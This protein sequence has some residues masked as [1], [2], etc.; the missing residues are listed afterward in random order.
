MPVRILGIRHGEVENPNNVIY[1]RL[2]GFHLSRRG[3]DAAGSLARKLAD[4]HVVAVYASPLERAQETA[5]ALAGPHGLGVLT[6]DRLLEWSFWTHWQG[7]PWLT[8]RDEAPEVFR[9][10][11]D[12]PAS[13]CPADPLP[14]VGARVMAWVAEAAA[15]HEE[16]VVLG[17]SHEA[18]LAAALLGANTLPMSGFAGTHVPHLG[19]VRLHPLPADVVDPASA[20]GYA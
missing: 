5:S 6:D 18:P 16:G 2:P 4:A 12:D 15:A 20:T 17:V 14:A 13:L 9:L 19:A 8:V 3:S 7:K 11:A 1:A 10:F